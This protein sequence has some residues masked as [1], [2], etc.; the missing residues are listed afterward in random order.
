MKKILVVGSLVE[1]LISLGERLPSSGETLE[2]SSFSKAP[3]GKGANQAAAASLLGISVDFVG[4]TGDDIFA[5]DLVTSLR[6]KGVNTTKVLRAKNCS[7]GVSSISI[8]KKERG[9]ENRIFMFPGGNAL[10]SVND[11]KFL[12]ETIKDYDALI[13]QFEIPMEVDEYL[14]ELAHKNNVFV[15]LNPAP[16]KEISGKLLD[17]V[18]LLVPNEHEA[19][20]LTNKP[21]DIDYLKGVNITQVRECAKDLFNKG[22]KN[23]VITLGNNGSYLLNKD[24]EVIV[25]AVNDVKS[26]D[27][28][29]AGDSYLGA[30]VASLVNGF[31]YEKAM[32]IASHVSA[33]VV[34][35]IG[36]LP[37]LP[38]NREVY[39]FMNSKGEKKL[40]KEF[41]DAFAFNN[42][43]EEQL[44][45]YK[46]TVLIETEKSLKQVDEVELYKALN[47]ILHS[48]SSGG[49]VHI[50]GIGK[51]SHVAE[52][53]ASLI[54]STGTPTYFLH[55]TEAV[56]GSSGQLIPDDIL[57]AISNSGETLELKATI[58][59]AKRNGCLLIGVSGNKD[60]WLAKNSDAFLLAHVDKEGGQLNKAPRASI[61]SEI[62]ALQMLS[63]L[64]Q[65]VKSI[66][67][68]QYVMWH[69]GGK[70][71]GTY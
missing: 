30:L 36:A 63:I 49:R 2:A 7:S 17:N 62:I 53:I 46:K 71:G 22:V 11:V 60:S 38:T 4:K 33:I 14:A 44:D 16:A 3:G 67:K 68:E 39:E 28:T 8:E 12:E 18:D 47:L 41:K 19:S 6:S 57:I 45:I 26:V 23:V 24:G 52:Y 10:L 40:A 20:L 29:A 55:G 56:H 61:L 69:P 31:D 5:R 64:L 48:E 43:L 58:E 54:S 9:N 70:L 51:P 34:G 42:T 21:I 13:L 35:K 65:G 37:S 1:D 59:A 27:P 25:S 15:A 66:S 32:K 50:T